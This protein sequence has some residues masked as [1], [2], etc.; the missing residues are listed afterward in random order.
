M[1][2]YEEQDIVVER[3][4]VCVYFA[5]DI[6]G[7]E[8][9]QPEDLNFEHDVYGSSSYGA[10]SYGYNSCGDYE[11]ENLDL[12]YE[13]A[14]KLANLIKEKRDKLFDFLEGKKHED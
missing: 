13:C 3:Q 10:L 4:R 5:C 7:A 1:R 2:K 12:C 11:S 14:E 9:T 6:C 8:S